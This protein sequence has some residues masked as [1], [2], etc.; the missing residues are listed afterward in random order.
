MRSEADE[1]VLNYFVLCDHV[2]SEAN[3]N[4]QSIIGIYSAMVSDILPLRMDISVAFSARVQS[5]V[6]RRF[7]LAV[8]APDGALMF[9]TPDLPIDWNAVEAGLAVYNSN[10][11]Q[12]GVG[13]RG[14]M[15]ISYGVYTAAMY[16][17]GQLFCT[18]PLTISAP[19]TPKPPS[20]TML[21]D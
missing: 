19:A 18:Y 7:N 4:K 6:P 16:C 3:T 9:S 11:L 8:T 20:L 10:S 14:L 17:D 12:L 21:Q 13:L 5:A 2:I 1:L 15:F